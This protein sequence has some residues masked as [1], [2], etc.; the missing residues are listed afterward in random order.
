MKIL[1]AEDEA[2]TRLRIVRM[3]EELGHEP[4]ACH[5]GEAAWERF[6]SEPFRVVI[7][8]W[9]MPGCDGTTLCRR[10]RERPSTDY[11]YFIL[12]TAR[13]PGE[14]PFDYLVG[15]QVDDFLLKPV[16]LGA[17]WRRLRVAERILGFTTQVRQLESLLPICAYCH[18]MR[19]ETGTGWEPIE[20]YVSAR[21]GSHFSHGIC[22]EC[23]ARLRAGGG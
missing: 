23:D 8:D 16:E 3:L 13:E 4:V 15:D 9:D 5:D 11:T 2:I 19:D 17:I 6:S 22:P 20:E 1:L 18:R 12:I 14:L 7:S 21:T 10:I